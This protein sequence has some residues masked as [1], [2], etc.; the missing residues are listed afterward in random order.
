MLSSLKKLTYKKAII[1][2]LLAGL[3]FFVITRVIF[4]VAEIRRP[5]EIQEEP[6][7]P[8]FVEVRSL[9]EV[10]SYSHLEVG[11]VKASPEI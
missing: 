9:D 5:E 1:F 8:T 10:P 3:G 11:T 2:G 7:I 6:I 4:I